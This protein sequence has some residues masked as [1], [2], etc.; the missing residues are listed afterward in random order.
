MEPSLI[1]Q[2]SPATFS[3]KREKGR[4]EPLYLSSLKVGKM[5]ESRRP[6]RENSL[7]TNSAGSAWHRPIAL[8]R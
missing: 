5:R 8:I 6:V 4:A 2:A 1:R 7:L 3:R